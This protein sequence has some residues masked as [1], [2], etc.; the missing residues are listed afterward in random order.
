MKYKKL[1]GGISMS[2][3]SKIEPEE[4][5][6]IV[7]RYLKGEIGLNEAARLS[8]ICSNDIVIAWIRIY[9]EV[10]PVGLLDQPRNHSYSKE[11]RFSE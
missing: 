4:K 6:K 11:L 8:G 3:K 1:L 5:V 9:E 10:G 7:E 2:R